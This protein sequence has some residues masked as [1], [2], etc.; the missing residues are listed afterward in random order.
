MVRIES[1]FPLLTG[2]ITKNDVKV[3]NVAVEAYQPGFEDAAGN[4]FAT[5][6]FD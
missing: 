1:S 5:I 2:S 3:D 6:S 4:D